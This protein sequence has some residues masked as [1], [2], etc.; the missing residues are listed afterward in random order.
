MDN[1][2]ISKLRRS[3][4]TTDMKLRKHIS[5]CINL[6]SEKLY[7]NYNKRY[8]NLDINR[9]TFLSASRARST[10]GNPHLI[11]NDLVS[12]QESY[13][14]FAKIEQ[15]LIGQGSPSPIDEKILAQGKLYLSIVEGLIEELYQMIFQLC[16][17]YETSLPPDFPKDW[18]PV[19]SPSTV[20]P[21]EP[22]LE[23]KSMPIPAGL[24]ES[25]PIPAG[26]Q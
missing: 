25:M 5:I 26:P 11:W 6:L 1:L 21:N 16:H 15:Q 20:D 2:H 18:K 4:R 23:S 22:S 7:T 19:K 8:S 12:M 10:K 17:L 24:Q 13:N 9:S 3:L 14:A